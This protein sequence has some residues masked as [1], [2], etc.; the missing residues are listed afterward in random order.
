LRGS[1]F[2]RTSPSSFVSNCRGLRRCRL[3]F[4]LVDSPV[5]VLVLELVLVR[6][7]V[8][9]GVVWLGGFDA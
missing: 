5:F 9:F 7:L 3:F 2:I 1:R 6:V 4:T 8:L